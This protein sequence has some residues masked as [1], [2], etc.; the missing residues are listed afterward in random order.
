MGT[1]RTAIASKEMQLVLVGAKN[2]F[3][4]SRIQ[5]SNLGTTIPNTVIDEIGNSAHAGISIDMPDVN[6]TFSAFDVGVKVFSVLTGTDATAYPAGGV[7][8]S[9]M[10]QI[11]AVI[12]VKDPVLSDYVKDI[13]ARKLQVSQMSLSYSVDGESTEDYTAVGS[14]RRL[15]SRD[16]VVDRFIAGTTSFTLTQ[17]PIQLKNGNYGLSVILDGVYLTETASAPATGEY[18]LVGTTLTTFDSRTSTCIV[19]YQAA[20]AGTNWADVSDSLLPAAIKGRDVK[21]EISANSIPRVQS[22]TINGNLNPQPVKE[23]GSRATVG[24]QRQVPTVDGTITVLDTDT[25]LVNLFTTGSTTTSGTEWQMGEGCPTGGALSLAIKLIDPCTT[26]TVLKEVYL[27]DIRA[28]GETYSINVNGNA[29]L[30]INFK[31]NTGHLVI[32][33]GAK[34]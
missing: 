34:A 28:V 21:V 25:D 14:E 8:F 20:P 5:K 10:A 11:D 1:K 24:F 29:S 31:S 30:A 7:D 3:K 16:V 2:F 15:F 4:A 9:N 6:L 26:S 27:D 23:M 32:Y 22:I 13:H 33:S 18:R 12:F 17:T 19:V